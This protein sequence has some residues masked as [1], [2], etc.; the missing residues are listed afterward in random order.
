MNC[1]YIAAS[2]FTLSLRSR[3]F[4][5]AVLR[6]YDPTAGRILIDGKDLRS[7]NLASVHRHIGVVSQETQL[8]IVA[9]VEPMPPLKQSFG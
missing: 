7:L 9:G 1:F 6:F 8:V 5:L 3:A 4:G 2:C